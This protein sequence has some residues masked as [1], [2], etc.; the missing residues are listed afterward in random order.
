MTKSN[1]SYLIIIFG[2]MPS[3]LSWTFFLKFLNSQIMKT[4]DPT[5]VT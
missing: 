2:L 4:N 5:A 3:N 1:Q